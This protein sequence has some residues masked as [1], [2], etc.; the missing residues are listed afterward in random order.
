MGLQTNSYSKEHRTC[1]SVN[2]IKM[3]RLLILSVCVC[4]SVQK[5]AKSDDAWVKPPYC[6]G[7]DCPR[8]TV[9]EQG[10]GYELREYEEAQW[11]STET[12]SV[13]GTDRPNLFMRLFR[14]IDGE[15]VNNEKIPMTSPVVNKITPGSGPNC[16][17]IFK[18]SF[19]IEYSRQ[20]DAPEPSADNVFLDKFAV[21]KVYVRSFSGYATE[22]DYLRNLYLLADSIGDP[23]KFRT[24]HYMTAGY[25][26]PF[27]PFNR[28][29]EVWLVSVS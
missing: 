13:D 20:E 15:N 3:L 18:Q 7:N 12:A 14:Y 22:D 19:Y 11:V 16:E 28:H 29:N 17:T 27:Q 10:E 6:R 21:V 5:A 25:D 26:S 2:Y 8:F 23:A 1:S 24:D 9:L 4:L